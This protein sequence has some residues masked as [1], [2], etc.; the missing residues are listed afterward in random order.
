MRAGMVLKRRVFI[1]SSVEALPVANEVKTYLSRWAD[2]TMWNDDVFTFNTSYFDTLLKSLS[3]Y[4]LGILVATADDFTTSREKLFDAPR[5]NVVLEFGLFLGALGPRKVL[6]L[7]QDGTKLP[8]DLFGISSPTFPAEKGDARSSA[9]R[10]ICARIKRDFVDRTAATFDLG[11]LP[12][13]SLAYGYFDNFVRRTCDRLLDVKTIVVRGRRIPFDDF[14]FKILI[15]DDLSAD[16]YDKVK[17]RRHTQHWESI[18]INAG[19]LRPYDFHVDLS[20][21]AQGRI[22]IYDI[23]LTLNSLHQAIQQYL[24]KSSLGRDYYE[25]MLE[26][27]EIS[28]FQRVL[29]TLIGSNDIT[30]SRVSTEIVSV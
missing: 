9:L 18:K 6:F 12:S 4:D 14:R 24:E 21:N 27:R 26:Q 30:K 7:R 20:P 1:G 23:P 16:M 3:F 8:S 19:G 25:R 17:A 2:C 22:E 28:G 11:L 5:D 13:V 29:D 15:P 10:H